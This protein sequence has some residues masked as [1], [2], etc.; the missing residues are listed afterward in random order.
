MAYGLIAVYCD[1]DECKKTGNSRKEIK[2][3][4]HSSEEQLQTFKCP[5]CHQTI[6]RK[7]P[8]TFSNVL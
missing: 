4:Y 2:I 8:G 1:T 3:M 5:Y 6:E 7:L